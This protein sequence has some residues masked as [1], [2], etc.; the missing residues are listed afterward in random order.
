MS[1][2]CTKCNPKGKLQYFRILFAALLVSSIAIFEE[3]A[4]PFGLVSTTDKLSA[5]VFSAM[6]SPFYGTQ[7]AAGKSGQEE[8]LIVL[9]DE[10]FLK[11]KKQSWPLKTQTH[12]QV[13]ERLAA[14][15]ADSIFLD[16][17]FNAHSAK[18]ERQLGDLVLDIQ[19]IE[20]DYGTSIWLA[21][22]KHDPAPQ[23]A[24]VGHERFALAEMMVEEHEYALTQTVAGN[25]YPTAAYALYQDWCRKNQCTGDLSVLE[26]S[27]M[28]IQ[29]GYAPGE[30]LRD[31]YAAQGIECQSEAS[32]IVGKIWESL[33]LLVMKAFNGLSGAWKAN[34]T[35]N[36]FV[37]ASLIDSTPVDQLKEYVDGKTVL[38]GTKLDL[39]ADL[40]RS[41]V[42]GDLPGV[43]WHAAAL[44]NL[45]EYNDKFLREAPSN[46]GLSLSLI[47]VLTVTFLFA[48]LSAL[49][50]RLD[51]RSGITINDAERARLNLILGF[52]VIVS[53]GIIWG[54]V[55]SVYRWAPENWLGAILALAIV[56]SD[57]FTAIGEFCYRRR[58]VRGRLGVLIRRRI[59]P[60]TYQRRV[61]W[62]FY[63]SVK[64]TLMFVL[65]S[66]TAYL[67]MLI[68]LLVGL[69]NPNIS[70][71]SSILIAAT[72]LT[73]LGVLMYASI[74]KIRK[75]KL[76]K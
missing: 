37:S 20:E 26:D 75:Y 65:L 18:K 28:F 49:V 40:H 27:T 17:Y 5:T 76:K 51:D 23:Y 22:L 19:D 31:Y 56:N 67:L 55:V 30:R 12:R 1:N 53:M 59:K 57:P 11:Q 6:I 62:Q 14:A 41:T 16:V 43:F 13:L 29:W 70:L 60:F 25:Y 21:G 4:D 69:L 3:F 32:N 46:S 61:M 47:T 34:C 8:I 33:Q 72:Y 35:Y 48:A 15:G 64:S 71:P 66:I 36:N 39:V 38:V 63:S 2:S 42:H 10:S 74:K 58:P 54:G 7:Q 44:D 24:G 9:Y 73:A 52:F 45:I 68:Y 50:V